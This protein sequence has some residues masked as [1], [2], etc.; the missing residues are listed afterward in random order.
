MTDLDQSKAW[1]LSRRAA[2][3]YRQSGISLFLWEAIGISLEAHIPIPFDAYEYLTRVSKALGKPLNNDN[4]SIKS[5][6]Y[7]CLEMH[8]N[9]GRSLFNQR[10]I[11]ENDLRLKSIAQTLQNRNAQEEFLYRSGREPESLKRLERT[12]KKKLLKKLI[13]LNIES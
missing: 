4:Q 5:H 10:R 2:K 3:R 6:I 9:G 1:R 12:R 13:P 8:S 11:F 7:K